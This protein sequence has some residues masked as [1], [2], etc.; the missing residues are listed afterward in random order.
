MKELLF[1]LMIAK[2]KRVNEEII[3]AVSKFLRLFKKRYLLIEK[4]KKGN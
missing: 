2:I 1:R 3:K 4:F